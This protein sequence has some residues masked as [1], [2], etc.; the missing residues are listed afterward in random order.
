MTP[1]ER[2]A[3]RRPVRSIRAVAEGSGS[4]ADPEPPAGGTAE[5][6]RIRKEIAET[7]EELG[8]TVAALSRKA[9]VKTRVSEKEAERRDELKERQHD[10]KE[11]VTGIGG[12]VG[13]A[14]PDDVKQTAS[15]AVT[16][17]AGTTSE[18]PLPALAGAF[19]AGLV[20]GV[21]L[22]RRT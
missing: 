6:E 7:R 14:T 13:E 22:G 20:M 21:M 16:E 17:V 11:K 19:A 4:S 15:K 3:P 10:L 9:D 12:R 1:N 5:H 2:Y 8:A 18:R